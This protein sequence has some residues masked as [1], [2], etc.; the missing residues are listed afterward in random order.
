LKVLVQG[1]V[2]EDATLKDLALDAGRTGSGAAFATLASEVTK[3]AA[4]LAA[5]HTSGVEHGDLVTW[6]EQAHD[7]ERVV[8]RVARLAPETAGAA[9]PYLR[10]LAA[11]A[12]EHP[13][14]PAGAAH[15]SFRPAQVLLAGGG[16]A[17][18]D[19]DG[20]CTAEPAIDV[21]LF[22]AALR[23]ATLRTTPEGAIAAR[24]AAIDDVCE[25]FLAAYEAAAPVSRARVA[26]WEGLYLLTFVLNCWTKVRPGRITGLM[27]LLTSHVD[28]MEGRFS[29]SSGRR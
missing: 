8:E 28:D 24:V 3:A 14:D 25:Q 17:F 16:I 9:D 27:T 13:A 18:I 29:G 11:I 2:P 23:D 10:A 7:T 21:A 1:A 5:L 22:R 4:G 12:T 26:V 15:R 6:D 19:F 20:L